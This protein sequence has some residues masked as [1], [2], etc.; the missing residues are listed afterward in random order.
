MEL[1]H[2]YN[3]VGNFWEMMGYLLE[4]K[5]EGAKF[6][7]SIILLIVEWRSIMLPLEL[8]R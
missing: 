1:Y 2:Y 5:G 7:T 8:L 3:D 6:G 4:G